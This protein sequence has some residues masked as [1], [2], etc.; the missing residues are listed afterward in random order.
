MLSFSLDTNLCSGSPL[1]L[2]VVKCCM[3]EMLLP[4]YYW[5]PTWRVHRLL[6]IWHANLEG[7]FEGWT[8][9]TIYLFST[10][11]TQESPPGPGLN[12][13][14]LLWCLSTS[15]QTWGFRTCQRYVKWNQSL[16]LGEWWTLSFRIS[17]QRLT[18]SKSASSDKNSFPKSSEIH[19]NWKWHTG[20]PIISPPSTFL[21]ITP[22]L[23]KISH[24]RN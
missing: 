5:K 8:L 15:W 18:H 1:P 7:R 10:C 11:E 14:K 19:G 16:C 3:P 23:Y 12:I 21:L 9:D 6:C 13:W 17:S 24:T 20:Q 22:I 4:S 2:C